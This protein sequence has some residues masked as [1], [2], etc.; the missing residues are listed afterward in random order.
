MVGMFPASVTPEMRDDIYA[1]VSIDCD[2]YTPILEGLKFFWPRL[3]VDGVIFIHDYS[4]GYWAGATKAVD[5]FCQKQGVAGMLL[6][7]LAGSYVL[8]RQ[9][10]SG[11]LE[12][13]D[14]EKTRM[15]SRQPAG[16][17]TRCVCKMRWN[18]C[19]RQPNLLEP[20]TSQAPST[21]RGHGVLQRRCAR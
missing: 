5:Y 3:V 15:N 16:N 20:K 4:S 7:D 9:R 19:K 1:F 17:L 2:I 21:I 8:T 13:R 10:Q 14:L 18:G 11:A 6:S 12:N